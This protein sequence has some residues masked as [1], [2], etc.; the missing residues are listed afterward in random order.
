MDRFETC[1]RNVHDARRRSR[2]VSGSWEE[3]S[4]EYR[5]NTLRDVHA[6]IG[7]WDPLTLS[8]WLWHPVTAYRYWKY[9]RSLYQ[10]PQ[11]R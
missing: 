7:V 2:L 9:R 10:A 3:Q 8:D 4:D 11:G 5:V 1:A 6:A